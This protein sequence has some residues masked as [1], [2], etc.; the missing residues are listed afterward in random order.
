MTVPYRPV[1]ISD[2]IA[3]T[4]R[5]YADGLALVEALIDLRADTKDPD[6]LATVKRVQ[7]LLVCENPHGALHFA[8]F[9]ANLLAA[10]AVE[11]AG[12]DDRDPRDLV[13]AWR[14]E[15]AATL[16]LGEQRLTEEFGEGGGTA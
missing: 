10:V 8:A 6:R 3:R 12:L 11:T 15:A 16:D 14:R 9:A 7:H 5:A 2:I 1:A 4:Q 13:A